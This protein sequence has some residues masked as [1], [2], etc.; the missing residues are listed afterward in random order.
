MKYYKNLKFL[1]LTI[2]SIICGIFNLY[3]PIA[4]SAQFNQNNLIKSSNKFNTPSIKI[5]EVDEIPVESAEKSCTWWDIALEVNECLPVSRSANNKI[6]QIISPRDTHLLTSQPII[7][8]N[9]LQGV[10]SYEVKVMMKGEFVDKAIWKKTVDGNE[11]IYNGKSLQPGVQYYVVVETK[12][13]DKISSEEENMEIFFEILDRNKAK[14]IQISIEQTNF[15]DPQ[16]VLKLAKLY[17]QENLDSEAIELLEDFISENP[18]NVNV[19]IYNFL[20]IKYRDEDLYNHS[21]QTYLKLKTFLEKSN[22]SN[23]SVTLENLVIPLMVINKINKN[24]KQ[25]VIYGKEAI[26]ICQQL[27]DIDKVKK[28]RSQVEELENKIQ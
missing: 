14:K 6:P 11:I 26:S 24:W 18:E 17:D 25:A 28:L 1:N 5:A 10:K 21:E 12:N 9:A 16:Q 22:N 3:F 23:L 8:W 2:L 13:R 7:K 15:K 19:S 4:V 27:N 20:G